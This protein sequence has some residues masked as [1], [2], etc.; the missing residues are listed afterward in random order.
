MANA[1]LFD[2]LVQRAKQLKVNQPQSES[3]VSQSL[4]AIQMAKSETVHQA[5][6]EMEDVKAQV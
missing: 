5:I 6:A 2:N 4:E 3:V 1:A